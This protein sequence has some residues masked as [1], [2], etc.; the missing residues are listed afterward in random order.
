MMFLRFLSVCVLFVAYASNVY[1]TQH[2]VQ[3][4][5]MIHSYVD[6]LT[7]DPVS[8]GRLD[9]TF[10]SLDTNGDMEISKEELYQHL[11][12]GMISSAEL[13][14]LQEFDTDKS[15]S[16]SAHEFRMGPLHMATFESN[17]TLIRRLQRAVQ[18]DAA[19]AQENTVES[20][21]TEGDESTSLVELESQ[22]EA[23]LA[24]AQ[25]APAAGAPPAPGAPPAVAAP[26]LPI[27]KF[28]IPSFE[29][30][31][32]V[33]CQYFVQ[34]IQG[35]IFS[36]LSADGGNA[37]AV[38]QGPFAGDQ[39]AAEGTAEQKSF[40][41]LSA[42][43]MAAAR[44]GPF[45]GSA[46]LPNAAQAAQQTLNVRKVNAQLQKRPGGSG[47]VR[48]VTE[49][50]L[51]SLCAVDKFPQIFSQYCSNFQSQYTFNAIRKGLFFNLPY[52]EVCQAAELCRE[53]SYLADASSVHSAKVS[54]FYND[55]RG[56]CGLLGGPRER[57][58]GRGQVVGKVVCEVHGIV[59]A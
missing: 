49:D 47:L 59:V 22:V 26:K 3:A 29:D 53:D 51:T 19:F 18:K 46:A 58:A 16:I 44:D 33:I 4:A 28:G 43:M 7:N 27:S 10:K 8:L 5:N 32:C 11:K 57:T 55:Q 37:D 20:E 40:I 24:D 41:A 15:G 30:E 34:R 21:S 56:I 52:T 14:L 31:Q 38:K 45:A 42:N 50:T 39:Q 35:N 36:R 12:D 23:F 1:A 2:E 17:P 9:N 54:A 48:L 6:K 25:P 13:V